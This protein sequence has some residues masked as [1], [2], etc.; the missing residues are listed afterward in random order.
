MIS[1]TVKL[2]CDNC[3]KA[4][5]CEISLKVLSPLGYPPSMI[6]DSF[7][8]GWRLHTFLGTFAYARKAKLICSQDCQDVMSKM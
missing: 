4:E 1:T 5:E 2:T 6:P 8:F 3:G 7:P